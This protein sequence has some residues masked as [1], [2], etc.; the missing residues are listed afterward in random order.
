MTK[1]KF[2]LAA[3]AA[4]IGF[5]TLSHAAE[6]RRSN[7]TYRTVRGKTVPAIC[8]PVNPTMAQLEIFKQIHCRPAPEAVICVVQFRDG[9]QTIPVVLIK[10]LYV[11][12]SKE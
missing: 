1:L 3:V 12:C 7:I 2:T 6:N 4:I 5:T 9:K 11:A 8:L 10:G